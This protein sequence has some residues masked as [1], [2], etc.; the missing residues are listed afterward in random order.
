M[1]TSD[2]IALIVSC[3]AVVAALA[4]AGMLTTRVAALEANE[5]EVGSRAITPTGTG[6][7]G[8]IRLVEADLRPGD[9][10][11][12]EL[13]S[14]STLDPATYGAL[15]GT[16]I[17]LVTAAGEEDV[18]RGPLEPGVLENARRSRSGTCLEVGRGAIELPGRYVTELTWSGPLPEPDVRFRARTMARRSLEAGD[19]NQVFAILVLVLLAALA[20][21]ARPL[22]PLSSGRPLRVAL[23]LATVSA[24]VLWFFMAVVTPLLPR[25]SAWGLLSGVALAVVEVGLAVAF[26]GAARLDVL[27]V[28]RISPEDGA[29]GLAPPSAA[30]RAM[31]YLLLALAPVF[32][33]LLFRIAQLALRIVPS[34]GEAPIEAF[35]AWPSGMLS[36]AALAVIAPLAEEVFFR[37]MVFGV[38]SGD[39]KSRG[40]VLLAALGSWLVFAAVHLPQTWGSWGGMLSIATA[41]AGFTL[42]R[43]ASGSVVVPAVA[44]LVYNGLLSAQ[45]LMAS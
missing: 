38:L 43:L 2:R 21:Y 25:G 14:S 36:F 27:G 8:A 24:L 31:P 17:V 37:G 11:T 12:F 34:T 26:A 41:G 16:A 45:G 4:V 19:R 40:R 22:R 23:A 30:R 39:G 44:H 42:L 35:V 10:V 32:G 13:C 3:T 7:A 1:S 33:V 20:L 28:G 29:P 5:L 9:E 15:L 6:E 18:V